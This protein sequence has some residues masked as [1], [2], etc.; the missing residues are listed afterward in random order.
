MTT[1]RTRAFGGYV[2]EA[3]LSAGTMT[4]AVAAQAQIELTWVLK[5]IA[6]ALGRL[7]SIYVNVRHILQS[8]TGFKGLDHVRQRFRPEELAAI[9]RA[10]DPVR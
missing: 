5:Q 3:V 6:K 7:E 10:I 9:A 4:P 2:V 8:V 1:R